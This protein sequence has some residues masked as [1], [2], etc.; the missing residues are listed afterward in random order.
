MNIRLANAADWP[1][2]WAILEPIFRAGETYPYPP[3]ITEIEAQ[4]VWMQIPTQT[5][6]LE[7]S[8]QQILGTY[9]IKPNQPGLGSHVCNCGYAIAESARG[10]GLGEALGRHSLATAI[11]LGFR[12]MQFNLVVKTNTAS[13]RIWEKLGFATIGCLPRAF[14]HAQFGEVDALVMYK[15]LIDPAS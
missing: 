5:F 8:G 13:I 15:Q 4:T 9:Y 7:D 6:V 11:A 1:A 2:I 12:A 14:Q 3:S 10:Q